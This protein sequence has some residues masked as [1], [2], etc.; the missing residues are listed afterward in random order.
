ME[1]SKWAR[2]MWPQGLG[3]WHAIVGTAEGV[4]TLACGRTR[5][6]PAVTAGRPG[7]EQCCPTCARFDD[8]RLAYTPETVTAPPKVVVAATSGG[9][10]DDLRVL[11]KQP[12]PC[13]CHRC[14][15]PANKAL[16]ERILAA[17]AKVRAEN[18]AGYERYLAEKEGAR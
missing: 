10:S 14:A 1:A 2:W 15:T 5:K 17:R 13:D 16:C 11:A 9:N 8:L 18:E 3:R 4:T 6:P 12:L 7:A